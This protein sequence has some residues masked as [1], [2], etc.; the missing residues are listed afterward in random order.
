MCHLW[1][2]EALLLRIRLPP[3]DLPPLNPTGATILTTSSSPGLTASTRY[4]LSSIDRK[5]VC[6]PMGIGSSGYVLPHNTIAL[7]Q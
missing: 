7:V 5:A 4:G 3:D 2:A 1:D 6:R